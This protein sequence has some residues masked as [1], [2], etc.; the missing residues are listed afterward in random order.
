MK[1]KI[2]WICPS[3]KRPDRL[4]R[5][6]NSWMLTTEGLSDLL[7]V[8][9]SDDQ[10]YEGII[11][12]YPNVMWEITEPVFGS[13]LHLI[14]TKAVKYSTEYNYIGFMEDDIV[15][16]TNKYESKFILKLKELGNTG[17]IHARDGVDKKRFISI[18]VV[19]THIIRTL[20]WFAPTCLKSL[21]ADN[22]WRA[23]AD[24]LGTYFKFEDVMIRHYHYSKHA[25]VIKDEISAVVD[26]NYNVD[27]ASYKLYMETEFVNDMRKIK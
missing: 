2:L 21:W 10:S 1:E 14:N 27:A 8:I 24:H 9:D 22:F 23:M 11:K 6:I 15:F 16:E 3:R 4:D 25:D 19:D 18:P 17:I 5:L 13:F 26:G 20:G 7:V 12:K